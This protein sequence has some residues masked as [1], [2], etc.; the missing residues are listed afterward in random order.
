MIT[1]CRLGSCELPATLRGGFCS[2]AHRDEH[3][4]AGW[5]RRK[6]KQREQEA[7]AILGVSQYS[8]G[9]AIPG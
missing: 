1:E 3:R 9:R 4:R 7:D 5:R 6:P 2:E 8:D